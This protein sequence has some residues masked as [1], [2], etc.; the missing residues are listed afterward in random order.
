VT[1]TRSIAGKDLRVLWRSPIPYVVGALFNLVLALLYVSEL[2]TR[3]QALMQPMFPIAG[4]LLVALVPILCMRAIAEEA[5]TGTLDVLLAVPVSGR[6]LVVGKWLACWVTAV[7]VIAPALT[8]AAVLRWFGRPDTGP[9][10]SGFLGLVL[11]T[12]ALSGI[13]LLAS[14][15]GPSQP[16]AAV[17]AL[18]ASLLLWFARGGSP[19]S[20]V[21]ALLSRLSL[22]ERL[23]SFA[24]GV[25]DSADVVFLLVLTVATLVAATAVV[26]SRRCT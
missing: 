22:S 8:H 5:R 24:G 14:S 4:F 20:G 2:T 3:R 1:K 17:V 12:G 10:V 9:I 13:G 19:S 21:G 11:L 6:S 18:F 26:D 23:H 16:L 25:L 15:L 7:V